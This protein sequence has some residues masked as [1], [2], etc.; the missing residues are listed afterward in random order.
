MARQRNQR[1]GSSIARKS[2]SSTTC[3]QWFAQRFAKKALDRGAFVNIKQR[4]FVGLPG[5]VHAPETH[6]GIANHEVDFR[7]V[8]RGAQ[9]TDP[10]IKF[11][12][13][14]DVENQ[15]PI[16]QGDVG[17]K[18]F[19]VLPQRAIRGGEYLDRKSR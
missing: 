4:G 9:L 5:Q 8:D 11:A 6:Q 13:I 2:V 18:R 14:L 17:A 15:I 16:H 10:G 3:E 19:V 7:P 1:A 12:P